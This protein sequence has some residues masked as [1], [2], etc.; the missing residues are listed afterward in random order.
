MLVVVCQVAGN[1]NLGAGFS[2]TSSGLPWHTDWADVFPPKHTFYFTLFRLY[3][4]QLRAQLGVGLQYKVELKDYSNTAGT[5]S[6]GVQ[7][8]GSASAGTAYTYSEVTRWAWQGAPDLPTH[9]TFKNVAFFCCVVCRGFGA[10]KAS[11]PV[12]RLGARHP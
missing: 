3:G 9:L 12:C 5:V 10:F 6:A 11:A 2:L 8:S 7:Y 1:M 4:A